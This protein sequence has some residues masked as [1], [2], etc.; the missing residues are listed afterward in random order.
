[1]DH[2]SPGNLE[3]VVLTHQWNEGEIVRDRLDA[4]PKVDCFGF[5]FGGVPG[6][7]AV[8]CSLPFPS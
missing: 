1:M 4:M 5:G 2:E 6:Y 3:E 7:A 8:A